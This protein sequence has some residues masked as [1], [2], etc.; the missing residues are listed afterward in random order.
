M[1]LQMSI[2]SM[3]RWV[4]KDE[5]NEYDVFL[6]F[7]LQKWQNMSFKLNEIIND[8]KEFKM[9]FSRSIFLKRAVL[10]TEFRIHDQEN[11]HDMFRS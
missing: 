3:S 1:Q 5:K 9:K 6:R 2:F 8:L 10:K 11:L 7:F 4:W